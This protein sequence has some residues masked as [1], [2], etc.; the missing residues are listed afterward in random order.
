MAA[1]PS[2]GKALEG[3]AIGC[4]SL[5]GTLAPSARCVRHP[6]DSADRRMVHL[7]CV[8]ACACRCV[9][10][11]ALLVLRMFL[12]PGV[13]GGRIPQFVEYERGW[14]FEPHG[15]RRARGGGENGNQGLWR[16]K[17]VMWAKALHLLMMC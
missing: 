8:C 14:P 2:G 16:G 15:A 3:S 13:E 7:S 6:G 11:H 10:V 4:G 1:S 5:L 17:L 9:V 12:E